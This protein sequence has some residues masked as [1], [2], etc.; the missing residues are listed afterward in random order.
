MGNVCTETKH[1]HPQSE[2]YGTT[3][4]EAGV[5]LPQAKEFWKLPGAGRAEEGFS[6]AVF[7]RS[8]A[9][10]TSCFWASG[11]RSC[12]RINTVV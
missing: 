8:M 2:G 5:L 9:Q 6:P 3:E 7:G 12:A 4:A 10:L 11:L 1:R